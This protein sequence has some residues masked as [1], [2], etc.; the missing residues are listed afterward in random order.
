MTFWKTLLEKLNQHGELAL[1]YVLKSTGSSPGRQGFRLIVAPDG[2]ME[3][4][5]GGGIMEQKL[6]E[7]ARSKLSEGGF[8]P[9]V[10]KQIHKP[11]AGKNRSGMIC[12]GEQVVAFYH[13][14]SSDSSIFEKLIHSDEPA[15]QL[16]QEGI[17]FTTGKQET[18]KVRLSELGENRW[19]LI[20]RPGIQPTA[21]IFGGG[22]VGLAMSR[23][24]AQ[25]DFR[26]VVLDDREGLNTMEKNTWADEKKVIDYR[27]A[28]Q[29][30]KEGPNSYVIIM[31]FGYRPDEVIIRRLLDLEFRYI[32]MMGSQNKIETMWEVL[33]RD[34]YTDEQLNKVNAPI[35][36]PIKSETTEEIAVSIAAEIIKVKNTTD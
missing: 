34:G 6:V 4:T 22:H 17:S 35:G 3:G 27:Q 29:H 5:I 20:E 8:T 13:I 7:L 12:D 33:R 11:E 9:F 2:D 21:Y 26:V 1:L 25:L 18:E 30:V 14:N 28:E 36:L 31:S 16:T 19:E 23:T 24:M 32:G 10:K 15:V